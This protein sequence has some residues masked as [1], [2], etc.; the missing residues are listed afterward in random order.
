MGRRKKTNKTVVIIP[1]PQTPVQNKGNKKKRNKRKERK[2][3]NLKYNFARDN[4][5]Y[6]ALSL[7]D[8]WRYRRA[9]IP[10]QLTTPSCT[11]SLIFKTTLTAVQASAPLVS[12]GYCASIALVP[13]LFASGSAQ[14][15]IF[16]AA[17]GGGVNNWNLAAGGGQFSN[18]ATLLAA[19][20]A[21]RVVSASVAMWNSSSMANNAGYCSPWSIPS[22]GYN[23]LFSTNFGNVTASTIANLAFSTKK[24]MQQGCVCAVNYLPADFVDYT[25]MQNTSATWP[26][27]LGVIGATC[28]GIPANATIEAAVIMN[29]EFIP[30]SNYSV[31]LNPRN[32]KYDVKAMEFALNNISEDRRFFTSPLDMFNAT[33]APSDAEDA[34]IWDSV[35]QH[36]GNLPEY[37]RKFHMVR[38]A[39]NQGMSM[40]LPGE[41][42]PMPLGYQGGAA[43]MGSM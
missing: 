9:R 25:Y 43:G 11:T 34:S 20:N 3:A 5:P 37:F 10:D 16:F 15:N 23:S 8:P 4:A 28:F 31:L 32:S 39:L 40:F 12:A 13:A 17:A 24:P 41:G 33:T 2:A 1:K 22:G 6:Y 19:S 18:V 42:S 27:S 35:V 14:N 21:V 29:V 7:V 36:V 38:N 30:N 26:L